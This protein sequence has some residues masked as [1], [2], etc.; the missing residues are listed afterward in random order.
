M[1]DLIDSVLSIITILQSKADV[2]SLKNLTESLEIINSGD[3]RHFLDQ[4]YDQTPY[5]F[6]KDG[7][8]DV[9]TNYEAVLEGRD[10]IESAFSE[11]RK[12]LNQIV[13]DGEKIRKL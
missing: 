3:V 7:L 9:K 5:A 1:H 6:A 2:A 4:S 10:N 12:I 8:D 13:K 11:N